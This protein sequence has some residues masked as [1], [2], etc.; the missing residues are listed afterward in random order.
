MA[1]KIGRSRDDLRKASEHL[2]YEFWMLVGLARILSSGSFGPGV[3]SNGLIESFTIHARLLLDFFFDQKPRP[4]DVLAA[5]Y[6]TDLAAWEMYRGDE[7]NLLKKLDARVGKEIAH[8]TYGRLTVAPQE[9]AYEFLAIAKELHSLMERFNERADQD[10]LG[11]SW[12]G[13]WAATLP[14]V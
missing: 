9:K 7:S 1:Q 2:Y 14:D 4:D 6:I 5:H 12:R 8:L 13:N 11:D 3:I 10:L